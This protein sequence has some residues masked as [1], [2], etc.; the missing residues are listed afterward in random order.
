MILYAWRYHWPRHMELPNT[1]AHTCRDTHTH[2]NTRTKNTKIEKTKERNQQTTVT[3]LGENKRLHLESSKQIYCI[4]SYII[5]L[6]VIIKAIFTSLHIVIGIFIPHTH[7]HTHTHTHMIYIC[8]YTYLLLSSC[9]IP[10]LIDIGIF[11]L[12]AHTHTQIYVYLY[13]YIHT[14]CCPFLHAASDSIAR[15]HRDR[16]LYSM[17]TQ[18]HTLVMYIYTY[19][20][21]FLHL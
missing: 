14:F 20:S 5:S 10:L 12:H 8:T 11:T 4:I 3:H 16:Y 21:S 2:A 19:I 13:M 1:H 18:I 17:R 6:W 9:R 15:W 7:T